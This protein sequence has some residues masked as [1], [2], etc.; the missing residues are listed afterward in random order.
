MVHRRPRR[1]RDL[2]GSAGTDAALEAIAV[3][4]AVVLLFAVAL[5]LVAL[6]VGK[7]REQTAEAGSNGAVE[8]A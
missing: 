6:V 5:F 2:A 3:D 7:L 8:G 1:A 4:L